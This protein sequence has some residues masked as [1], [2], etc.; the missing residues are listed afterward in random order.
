MAPL[1]PVC[2]NAAFHGSG[3][4]L[5]KVSRP[6][7]SPLQYP[8]CA[9]EPPEHLL[10]TVPAQFK[11]PCVRPAGSSIHVPSALPLSTPPR[12]SPSVPS[13]RPH[14]SHRGP[15]FTSRPYSLNTLPAP[16]KP[17]VPPSRTML[18]A[19][20][21]GSPPSFSYGSISLNASHFTLLSLLRTYPKQP[22]PLAMSSRHILLPA[23]LRWRCWPRFPPHPQYRCQ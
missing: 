22:A 1:I 3:P 6:H 5:L 13:S 18:L 9:A 10:A 4:S 12:R 17:I 21:S 15:P 20:F 16:R 2:S 23:V 11:S 19:R 7:A 8:H 14:S